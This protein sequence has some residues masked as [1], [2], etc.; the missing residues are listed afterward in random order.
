MGLNKTLILVMGQPVKT[1]YAMINGLMILVLS[2]C[3]V[4]SCL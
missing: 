4:L 2:E 3:H 1:P